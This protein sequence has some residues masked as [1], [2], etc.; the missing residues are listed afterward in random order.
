MRKTTQAIKQAWL[1]GLKKKTANT[2]TDGRL[3]ELFGNKIIE[4]RDDGTYWTMAGWNTST[5]RERLNGI[6]NLDIYCRDGI[7]YI[8]KNEIDCTKWYKK[9]IYL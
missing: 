6:L 8:G 1:L 5:T 7:A 2:Y 9:R 3:V 4:K